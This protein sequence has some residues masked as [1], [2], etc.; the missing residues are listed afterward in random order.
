MRVLADL[1]ERNMLLSFAV[2]YEELHPDVGHVKLLAQTLVD[3]GFRDVAVRIAKAASYDGVTLQQYTHPVIPVPAYKGTGNAPE[4]ALVLALIR[5][6][7]EFDSAAVSHAGARG[8]MQIMPQQARHDAKLADVSYRPNDLTTDP[9]YNMQLGMAE[10]SSYLGDWGNS[11]ILAAAAYN[12]GPNRAKKWIAAFGDPRSPSVDPIDWVEE[13]PFSETRNYVQRVIE[14]TQAYR[15][16]LAGHAKPLGILAD[17]YAPNPPPSKVL[18][19]TPPPPAPVPVPMP[20][21][22]AADKAVSQGN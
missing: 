14:N 6:E 8:I 4:T 9:T 22:T 7:T 11:L 15:S 18:V 13:I 12:A 2:R 3:I 21:P 17:L 16:R 20:R 19:Y 1:G 10:F 5:Q